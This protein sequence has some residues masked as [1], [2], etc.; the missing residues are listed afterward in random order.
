MSFKYCNAFAYFRKVSNEDIYAVNLFCQ[1]I[2]H[3]PTNVVV[4][5]LGIQEEFWH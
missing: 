4:E 2:E 5:C 3:K 1:Y